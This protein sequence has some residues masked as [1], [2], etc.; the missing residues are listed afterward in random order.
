MAANVFIIQPQYNHYDYTTSTSAD[1]AHN[2]HTANNNNATNHTSSTNA[3]S[4]NTN[5]NND[6]N[7]TLPIM[8]V[9]SFVANL[10]NLE[11]VHYCI[12]SSNQHHQH[13][14]NLLL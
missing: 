4:T 10:S 8:D 3:T 14:P 11:E 5:N 9:D 12:D 7:A 6:F 13:Q 2:V 1:Y